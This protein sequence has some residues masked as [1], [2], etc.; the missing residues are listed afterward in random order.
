MECAR[1]GAKHKVPVIAD[2]GVKFSGDIVKALA[3]GASTVMIGSLFAGTD[4]A[5][6]DLV[7]YQGKSY[8]SYRGMGSLGAMGKGSKDRYFQSDVEDQGKFV[9]EGIEGRVAY[10]GPLQGSVY[11]LLG[12]IRS[13]MGY[14]GAQNIAELKERAKFVRISSAGLKESHVHDVYIT[15]EAPNYKL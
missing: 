6:G 8:K 2:G 11:Q 13:A 10:K 3:G 4:E 1:E 9:P 15:R 12:G 5:P 7:I 14:I